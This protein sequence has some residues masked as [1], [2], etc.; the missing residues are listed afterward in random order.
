MCILW[1]DEQD[2]FTY[3][4]LCFNAQNHGQVDMSNWELARKPVNGEVTQMLVAR[5]EWRPNEFQS[6]LIY[7]HEN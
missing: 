5:L 2:F 3:Y 4:N 7:L 6:P 1:F